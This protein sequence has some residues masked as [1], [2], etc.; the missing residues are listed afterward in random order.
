MTSGNEVSLLM[1]VSK[2]RILPLF[3][4]YTNAKLPYWSIL[5]YHNKCTVVITKMGRFVYP[6]WKK[7]HDRYLK[8]CSRFRVLL[9]LFF[10]IFSWSSPFCYRLL[11]A[12]WSSKEPLSRIVR[13]DWNLINDS[14]ATFG[15]LQSSMNWRKLFDFTCHQ[16]YTFLYFLRLYLLN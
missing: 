13:S 3:N 5:S 15:M 16:S 6:F 2:L 12:N 10:G 4:L 1:R 7:T 9:W 8:L 11:W 14:R